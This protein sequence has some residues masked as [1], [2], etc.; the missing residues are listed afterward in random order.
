MTTSSASAIVTIL[1]VGQRDGAVI[2]SPPDLLS[3]LCDL[4]ILFR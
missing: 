2:D 4:P 1:F 3:G